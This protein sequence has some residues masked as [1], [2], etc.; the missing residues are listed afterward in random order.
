MLKGICT[1][2]RNRSVTCLE[3][4]E[5]EE[6]IEIFRGVGVKWLNESRK[7]LLRNADCSLSV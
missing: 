7:M 6:A 4:K 5:L 3:G 1:S 2:M